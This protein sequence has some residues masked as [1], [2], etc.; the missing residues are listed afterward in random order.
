MKHIIKQILDNYLGIDIR[1]RPDKLKAIYNENLLG[2]LKRSMLAL[3][4]NKL[5]ISENILIMDFCNYVINYEHKTY[6]QLFQ[7]LAF[8]FFCADE[9]IK[10]YYIE[11][12]VG[13]GLNHSNTFLLEREVGMKG[14]LIEADPRQIKKISKYRDAKLI[15]CVAGSNN[16]IVSINLASTPELS[17]VGKENPNDNIVRSSTRNHTINSYTLDSILEQ[18]LN[19]CSLDYLSIDVEGYENEVLQGFTLN[20][21]QPKFINIEHNRDK[22]QM[23][24]FNDFFKENYTLVL[25]SI[26]D[27]DYWYLRNDIYEKKILSSGLVNP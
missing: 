4:N 6:S 8:L 7:D 18:N 5:N 24:K 25:E 3:Q 20:R 12:G 14:I 23:E 1:I 21:W 15:E 17:W 26:T 2:L 19:E 27:C 13:D 10:G 22:V 11:V 16:E 9:P